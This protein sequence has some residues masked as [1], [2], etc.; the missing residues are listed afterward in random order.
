MRT[1]SRSRI[2]TTIRVVQKCLLREFLVWGVRFDIYLLLSGCR[3]VIG[4]MSYPIA[5]YIYY[6]YIPW[7]WFVTCKKQRMTLLTL[8]PFLAQSGHMEFAVFQHIIT[9]RVKRVKKVMCFSDYSC[10]QLWAQREQYRH[11]REGWS[12]LV[13][14][15]WVG[16]KSRILSIKHR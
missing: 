9:E 4:R 6:V 16:L 8:W 11:V 5:P 3:A 12:W 7:F 2:L 1:T 10:A 14:G 15:L 13:I